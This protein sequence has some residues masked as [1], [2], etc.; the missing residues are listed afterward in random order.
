MSTLHPNADH[1]ILWIQMTSCSTKQLLPSNLHYQLEQ[2][3]P[4]QLINQNL[5]Y[6][7]IICLHVHHAYLNIAQNI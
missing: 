6:R 4:E 2:L 1:L 7:P 5:L 3:L